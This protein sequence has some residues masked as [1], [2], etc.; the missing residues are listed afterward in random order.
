MTS[1]EWPAE[2]GG[3]PRPR[4]R[5]EPTGIAFV[6]A[7][8]CDPPRHRPSHGAC[9]ESSWWL[10]LPSDREVVAMHLIPPLFADWEGRGRLHPHVTRLCHQDGPAGE[11]MAL[12]LGILL[13]ERG[14]NA[15]HCQALLLRAVATKTLPAAECGQQL[16]HSLRLLD[17]KLGPV[18]RALDACARQGAHREVW[19][20]MSGLLPA[21]LP[22]PGERANGVHTR[23]LEFA[24]EVA[25]WAGARGAIPEVA[26]IAARDGSSGL[27]RAARRLHEHFG[28]A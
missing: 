16:G 18:L 15:G 25:G 21:F 13:G 6:D 27:I 1:V 9:Y 19:Q 24:A 11:G 12:L 8:F 17:V 2:P 14:W 3:R 5:Q 10:V 20:I 28:R 7:L 4:I 26:G 23:A 22:R